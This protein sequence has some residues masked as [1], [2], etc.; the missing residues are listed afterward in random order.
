[1]IHFYS[2]GTYITHHS[3]NQGTV[4]EKCYWE[5]FSIIL[6]TF[7]CNSYSNI[8]GPNYHHASYDFPLSLAMA[9]GFH[10]SK[11]QKEAVEHS[12]LHLIKRMK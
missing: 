12:W 9:L 3:L 5:G 8:I 10:V 6:L 11:L 7:G 2:P 4:G 1:M